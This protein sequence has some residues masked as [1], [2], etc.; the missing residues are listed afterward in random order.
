MN[1]YPKYY[2]IKTRTSDGLLLDS[3]KEATRWE[4]LLLLQRAG[5]I[6]D[7]DRQVKFVLIPTQYE[8]RERYSKDGKR[9]K[10][11]KRVI[12]KECAYYADF[13]YT[14]TKTGEKIVE[15]T[16]GCTKGTAYDLFTIKRKLMLSVH[17]IK[18]RII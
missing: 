7:L 1:Y 5:N 17:K 18:V 15:D 4:Q 9:L 10:D 6:R 8:I 13:V 14:D 12:E 3:K 2:N 11:E 16:K